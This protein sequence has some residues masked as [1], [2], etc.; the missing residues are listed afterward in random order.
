M[1][2]PPKFSCEKCNFY[3]NK[4][5]HY[6]NHLLTKKHIEL[7]KS[8]EAIIK[9]QEE[10]KFICKGCN[11]RYKSYSGL[12]DHKKKCKAPDPE[13][14]ETLQKLDNL[15]KKFELLQNAIIEMCK[16]DPTIINNI[17]NNNNNNTTNN[18]ANINFS[19]YL[20]ENCKNAINFIDYIRT[21]NITLKDILQIADL[22]YV[23]GVSKILIDDFSSCKVNER[24]IYYHP[25]N[26]K[27]YVKDHDLEWKDKHEEVHDVFDRGTTVLDNKVYKLYDKSK[28]HIDPIQNTKIEKQIKKHSKVFNAKTEKEQDKIIENIKP[29]VKVPDDLIIAAAVVAEPKNI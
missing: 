28:T 17:T 9:Y 7:Q 8:E 11:K 14:V 22:G 10:R 13:K 18:T 5:Q 6:E 25:E 4:K 19:V 3:C 2:K 20:S 15:E 16:K 21:A 12:W 26:D 23:N 1:N 24:P 27:L 29:A